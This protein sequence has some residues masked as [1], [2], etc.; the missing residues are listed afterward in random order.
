MSAPPI[1]AV[2]PL[3]KCGRSIAIAPSARELTPNEIA[4]CAL[5]WAIS[6]EAPVRRSVLAFE[7]LHVTA[8]VE[9]DDRQWLEAV[10][11]SVLE[12]GGDDRARL[13]ESDG[14]GQVFLSESALRS[15]RRA[16]RIGSV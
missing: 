13:V 8:G 9:H 6:F 10:G 15:R 2:A 1:A 12:G 4:P 14:H 16:W 3:M 7:R 5:P 11:V